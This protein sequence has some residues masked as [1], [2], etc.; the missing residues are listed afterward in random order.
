MNRVDHRIGNRLNK[1]KKLPQ[2]TEPSAGTLSV[3]G[4]QGVPESDLMSKEQYQSVG[5]P[6]DTGRKEEDVKYK[7]K[8]KSGKKSPGK[9]IPMQNITGEVEETPQPESKGLSNTFVSALA[10][11]LPIVAGGLFEGSEGAVAAYKG[12]Q[13]GMDKMQ[14]RDLNE[15]GM[16]AK[17]DA[18]AAQQE[19]AEANRDLTREQMQMRKDM[20]LQ[21]MQLRRELAQGQQEAKQQELNF[22]VGKEAKKELVKFEEAETDAQKALRDL[23]SLKEEFEDYSRTS[24][25]GTGKYATAFG[26]TAPV[27]QK[28]EYLRSRFAG[29]G[30][31]EMVRIFD[32]MS[33]AIDSEGDRKKF[34]ST[35]PSIELDDE[36]NRKLLN[37]RI[38][39]AKNVL[40]K[41]IEK[42][43]KLV[44]Q[45]QQSS[46]SGISP[47]RQQIQEVLNRR[48][49][50]Q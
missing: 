16:Q 48:R 33:K 26:L 8:G 41:I 12:A 35:Q 31:E 27:S 14:E 2:D 47:T 17:E 11:F 22:K 13:Q 18:V 46:N 45:P 19:N 30:L 42:K 50:G 4:G 24:P 3:L 34:E 1:V 15:R 32:G 28:T 6:A 49:G 7:P 40:R 36:T 39:I 23:M 20:N 29:A 44:G 43:Q 21:N 37:R 25:F 10:N 5:Q 9:K 38:D